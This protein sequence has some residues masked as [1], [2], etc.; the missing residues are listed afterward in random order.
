MS[1]TASTTAS[2]AVK[3]TR[4]AIVGTGGRANM[5]IDP[6]AKPERFRESNELVGLCD[7]NEGRMRHH[8]RRLI[9]RFGYREVPMFPAADF[10]TMIKQTRPDVVVVC[11]VDA[12]HHHYICRAMELGCDVVTEKPMTIDADKCRQIWDTIDRTGRKVRV[13]F[14]YRFL[15]GAALLKELLTKKI[16]GDIIHADMEYLLNTSHGA[17]YYRRWH[18]EKDMSGGLMVHKATHHF[19][20]VNWWLDAVPDEV[21]G[22]G[23][24]GF[25][26]RK[27]AEARGV[28]VAY[29]H[30]T[31]AAQQGLTKDDPFALD[32]TA[33]GADGRGLY[34]D[35]RDYDGYRRDRNVFGEPIT[36]E[37]TMSAL[38]KYRTGTVLNY[39]LNSYLPREGL[40]IVFN[41][42]KGRLEYQEVHGSHIIAGQSDEELGEET[43]WENQ[44]IVHPMFGKPYKVS[45]P[46]A[47]G[48]HGGADPQ[49]QEQIFSPDPPTDTLGRYAQHG[50]GSA[51]IMVGIAA[52]ESFRTGRPVKISD[53][54]PQLGQAVHLHELP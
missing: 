38:V 45:I 6:I 8:Q 21:F 40:H 37:D 41:G 35:A 52:N 13:T 9:E 12:F 30:Y 14:N 20:L 31:E 47:K 39:S 53:L 11:T 50:Q 1:I 32:L 22:W 33:M 54:C 29:D 51:S 46:A 4:Y 2:T 26:G 3:V 34:W 36:I 18:R 24:L 16:V 17:D 23:R 43:R 5:F 28:K 10:E 27:N 49:L 15:P 25:Y 44:C 19:D 48:G 7:T 42:T